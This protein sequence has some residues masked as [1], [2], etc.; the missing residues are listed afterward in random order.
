MDRKQVEQV[1]RAV[2]ARME[3][4]SVAPVAPPRAE[5][6]PAAPTTPPPAPAAAA[7]LLFPV[8]VSARHVHLS[9]ADARA[10][11]GLDQLEKERDLSLPGQFLSRQ[12]V[13]LIGPK[14]TMEHVAVLGP[15]RSATQIEIAASDARLL[16]VRAPVRLSGDTANA[17]SLFLQAGESLVK[18]DAAIVAQRHLHLSPADAARIGVI[19]GQALSVRVHGTRPVTFEAVI[20]RI[21][22]EFL[23][24][25]HLDTDEANAAGVEPGCTCAIVGASAS[26]P[27][28][29]P[30]TPTVSKSPAAFE[31]KL[32]SERDAKALVLAGC[33]SLTLRAGQIATPLALDVLRAAGVSLHREGTP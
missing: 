29:I 18:A 27:A 14:G 26:S 24:T 33:A 13:R 4:P 30:P 20:A 28:P 12:R 3:Q 32:L 10:L 1:V 11:F 16:G 6:P 17:A 23:T 19:D 5:Q 15:T 25:L 2:L 8:E 31:G 22:P 21:S 9:A 7:D